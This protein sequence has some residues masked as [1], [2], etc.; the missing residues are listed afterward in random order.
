MAQ[1]QA[2]IPHPLADDLPCLLTPGCMTTP[3]IRVLL[4]VFIRQGSFEGATMQVECH[5]ISRGESALGKIRQEEF[6]DNP[7]AG[8]TDSTLGCPGRMGRDDDAD[9]LACFVQ[10]LFRTVVEGAAD[11]TL[12]M[13]Q[14]LVRRQVQAGL[15][16]RSIQQPIVFATRD[17]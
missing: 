17:I 1:L 10:E 13:R 3:T 15:D 12:R 6:I 2:E 14:V 11:S 7:G 4:H 16:F 9:P 5:D 8:D